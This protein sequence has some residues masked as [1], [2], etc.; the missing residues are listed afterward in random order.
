MMM[1]TFF[2]SLVVVRDYDPG[3]LGALTFETTNEVFKAELNSNGLVT[4]SLAKW[5]SCFCV[6]VHLWASLTCSCLKLVLLFTFEILLNG[7][8]IN[9]YLLL[10][11]LLLLLLSL[12]FIFNSFQNVFFLSFLFSF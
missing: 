3:A 12:L 1:M 7:N 8:I 2:L 10:L 4:L 5:V 9:I 11:L 6:G